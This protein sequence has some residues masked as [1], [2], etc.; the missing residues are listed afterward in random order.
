MKKLI[1]TVL[2]ISVAAFGFTGAASAFGGNEVTPYE[3]P[4]RH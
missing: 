1:L 3:M 2:I 4:S